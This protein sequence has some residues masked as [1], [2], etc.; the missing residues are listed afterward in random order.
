MNVKE[1]KALLIAA[2]HRGKASAACKDR[3][4]VA[5]PKVSSYKNLFGK[6]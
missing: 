4:E 5:L 1:G 2:K 3:D 6:L